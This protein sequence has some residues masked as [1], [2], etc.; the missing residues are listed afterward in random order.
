MSRARVARLEAMILNRS[1]DSSGLSPKGGGDMRDSLIKIVD[2]P[3]C[4]LSHRIKAII[5][6]G[7]LQLDDLAITI[8]AQSKYARSGVTC[9]D[10]GE[11]FSDANNGLSSGSTIPYA[12][13][14]SIGNRLL[15]GGPIAERQGVSNGPS[16][17]PGP[18]SGQ[19]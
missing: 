9:L 2:Q 4:S 5:E 3:L 16:S 10:I 18:I 6:L 19:G 8:A 1:V 14:L 7:K 17:A 15:N 12:L 13:A 11:W